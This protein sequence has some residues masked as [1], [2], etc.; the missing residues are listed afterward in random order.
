[1]N[2]NIEKKEKNFFQRHFGMLE[3][4]LLVLFALSFIIFLLY[5][6][7][8]S[9]IKQLDTINQ[10]NSVEYFIANNY[11]NLKNEYGI[12]ETKDCNLLLISN[13][14]SPR[15]LVKY[16]NRFKNDN[17]ID[18]F[19]NKN[20]R[21]Y[22]KIEKYNDYQNRVLKLKK[23]CEINNDNEAW[24]NNL[25]VLYS[26]NSHLI[27]KSE[28][29]FV[30]FLDG[31]TISCWDYKSNEYNNIDS[32]NYGFLEE[33]KRITFYLLSNGSEVYDS[34]VCTILIEQNK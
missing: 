30:S 19:I 11:E 26:L 12:G 34:R 6:E 1:M 31:K 2:F 3:Y 17:E 23:S 5:D 32:K 33:N 15:D 4:S 27:K 20:P 18:N 10:K 29:V 21:L 8:K 14:Y 9:L 25:S 13:E 22:K 28:D 24:N 7:E 16:S